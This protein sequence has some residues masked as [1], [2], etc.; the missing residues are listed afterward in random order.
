[1]CYEVRLDAKRCQLS[2][3]SVCGEI[4]GKIIDKA[5]EGRRIISSSIFVDE[6]V[7]VGWIYEEVG[8]ENTKN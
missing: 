2:L 4:S 3:K 6:Q 5:E 7:V 1:M 8:M